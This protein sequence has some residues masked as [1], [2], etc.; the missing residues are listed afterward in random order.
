MLPSDEITYYKYSAL[1]KGLPFAF[2]PSEL[3]VSSDDI[4][5][6]SLRD[7]HVI[8]WIKKGSGEYVVDFKEYGFEPNTLILLSKD[9]LHYFKPFEKGEV[10]IDSIV[11]IPEFIYKSER[12]LL[13]LFK[14]QAGFHEEGMQILKI[15]TS[16]LPRLQ[17]MADALHDIYVGWDAVYQDRAFYH[18][19]SLLLLECEMMVEGQRKAG[20]YSLDK[21]AQLLL[22]FNDLLEANF[23]TEFSVSFYAEALKIPAKTFSKLTKEHFKLSPKAVIDE[24]RILEIKRQLTGTA[25]SSKTIAYDL[26]FDEPTNMHKFF[27]KHQGMTTSEFREGN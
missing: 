2:T 24:R 21:D 8:F 27:K 9:Q 14:F 22:A 6:P 4:L 19:L 17:A 12:D 23:K 5:T 3:L 7:F 13:H 20:A 15:L 1:G 18:W 11:F 16:K 10:E 26:N 25:K